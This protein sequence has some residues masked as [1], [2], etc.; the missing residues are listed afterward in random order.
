MVNLNY[1]RALCGGK[2]KDCEK[3]GKYNIQV[4]NQRQ[5]T[6][7]EN[8]F[9]GILNYYEVKIRKINFTIEINPQRYERVLKDEIELIHEGGKYMNSIVVHACPKIII[10]HEIIENN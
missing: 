9:K 5:F 4:L 2:N 6:L 7:R 3:L 10:Q 1:L 8:I